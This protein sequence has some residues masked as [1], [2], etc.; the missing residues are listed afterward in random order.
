MLDLMFCLTQAYKTPKSGLLC[1]HP[2]LAWLTPDHVSLRMKRAWSGMR[3]GL[4][5]PRAV[6]LGATNVYQMLL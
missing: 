1:L 3:C 4:Q 6:L 2:L 5:M